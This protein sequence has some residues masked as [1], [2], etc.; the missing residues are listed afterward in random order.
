M[1]EKRSLLFESGKIDD[2]ELAHVVELERI[3]GK[4]NLENE[5]LKKGLS[6]SPRR[7][8]GVW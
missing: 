4:I 6:L 8:E 7:K 3:L 2:G 1:L 5:I